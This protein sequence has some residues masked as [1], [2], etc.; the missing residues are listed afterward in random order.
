[1][2]ID[3]FYKTL[4]SIV[5]CHGEKNAS[6]YVCNPGSSKKRDAA[7]GETLWGMSPA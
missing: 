3:F 7:S 6:D 4:I 1:M 2:F 5:D